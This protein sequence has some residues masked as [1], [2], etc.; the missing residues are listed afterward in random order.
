MIDLKTNVSNTLMHRFLY[1]TSCIAQAK[2]EC[3]RGG[4]G[5]EECGSRPTLANADEV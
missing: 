5:F 2:A 4:L 1:S 3:A